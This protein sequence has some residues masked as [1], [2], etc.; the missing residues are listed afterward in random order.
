M[1]SAIPPIITSIFLLIFGIIL[2]FVLLLVMNGYS[3][4]AAGRAL[5]IYGVWAFVTIILF[6][7]GSR[8]AARFASSKMNKAR[9]WV[10]NLLVIIICSLLGGLGIILGGFI[11]ILATAYL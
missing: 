5:I 1:K 9:P 6:G 10:I 7:I 3:E 4:S 11:S 2:F 8:Y